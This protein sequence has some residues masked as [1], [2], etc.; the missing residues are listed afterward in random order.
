MNMEIGVMPPE[1]PPRFA[2]DVLGRC[3][4]SGDRSGRRR[5]GCGCGIGGWRSRGGRSGG[6]LREGGSAG[7]QDGSAGQG[8]NE[9]LVTVEHCAPVPAFLGLTMEP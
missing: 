9:V 6:V 4:V 8:Q 7:H 3:S 5:R 1:C 2:G